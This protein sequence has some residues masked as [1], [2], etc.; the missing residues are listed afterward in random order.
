MYHALLSNRYL[1]TRVIPFIAVGAVA[2]CVALVVIVVSVMSGFLDMLKR[3]GRTLMGDVVIST[4][5]AGIPHYG[6]LIDRIVALPEA[7]A[8]TPL[9]ETLGLL[10]LPFPHGDRKDL[11]TVQVWAV[12]PATFASVTG[13]DETLWWHPPEPGK[14]S[15]L[16]EHDLRRQV[17][18]QLREDGL[19]LRDSRDGRPGI[20]PGIHVSRENRRLADGSYAPSSL[21][22]WMPLHAVSLTLVPITGAGK[23]AEPKE[24][25]FPVVNEFQSGV[26]QIDRQ[27]VLIPLEEG[28]KILR[29]G[30]ATLTD[31]GDLDDEGRPRVIGVDPAKVSR[32]LVRAADGVSPQALREAVDRAYLD[33]LE[34]LWL[35]DGALVKPPPRA[36]VLVLTWEQL[37]R[38]LIGPVE[39]EREMMRILFSIVYFVCAGLILSIFWAIVQ[40]KTRDIGILRSVGAPRAGIIWM[41]LRYGL[42][43]GVV[44]S[45]VGLV[46]A[47][48][49]VRNIN[50]IH[51]AIGRD[52]PRWA[53]ITSF[54]AAAAAVVAGSWYAWRGRV[55][56]ALLWAIASFAL[57][58]IGTGLLL[59]HG[60]LIWDP[61]VYYF[62]RIPN[63]VDRITAAITLVGAVVFSVIG[64]SIPAAKAA[65]TDPVRALRYE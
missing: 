50:A 27:R 9:V 57:A 14:E 5:Y 16:S 61:S 55:L 21:E 52:A 1:T 22:W 40:E 11:A 17:P 26:Y 58:V 43:I 39:K 15:K 18:A 3:S 36:A 49:V 29:L 6:R 47:E 8:A 35:D 42:V 62:S 23:L 7:A 30:E 45:L 13:F 51:D 38:D 53:W 32:V 64:A 59:H 34:E 25:V 54:A 37:L 44:G 31:P 33:F 12:D 63:E 19:A 56:P 20:V 65:D 2:L 28:Q 10:R 24:V 60:T 4:S 41:F 46:L 48:A